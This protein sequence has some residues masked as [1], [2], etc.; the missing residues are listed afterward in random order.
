MRDFRYIQVAEKKAKEL[1]AKFMITEPP[2]PVLEIAIGLGLDVIGYDLGDDI[3]GTL[4]IEN[5][6]GFIGYNPSHTKK[7]QRFTIGHEIGHFWLHYAENHLFVDKD[8]LVKYRSANSYTHKELIQEQQANA[9]SAALLMPEDFILEEL[10]KVPA[11]SEGELIETLAKVFDV[12][13][14]AMTFRLNNLNLNFLL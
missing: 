8:F 10:K 9:F 2:V 7:R 12:S 4:V 13:V 5:G 6:K 14:P 1:I 3:S 11:L